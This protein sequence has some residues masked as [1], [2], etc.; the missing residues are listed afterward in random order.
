MTL[1]ITYQELQQLVADKLQKNVELQAA[2][3]KA[4][5]ISV[6]H[7]E[8][9]G[10]SVDSSVDMELSVYGTDLY[11][12]YKV[13]PID[14]LKSK[15][16]SGLIDHYAPNL[17]NLAIDYFQSKY[18]QYNEIVEKVPNTDRLRIH[19]AAI[20]QLKNVLQYVEIDSIVPQEEG[21]QINARMKS[22]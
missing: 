11:A 18:P 13:V 20:P 19:L 15:F 12:D 17:V 14:N 2:G 16:L 7:L 10:K 21:L 6:H 5:K 9:M 1:F 3:D 8:F 4:L 22:N